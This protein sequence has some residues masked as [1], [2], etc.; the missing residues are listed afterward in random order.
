M[1]IVERNPFGTRSRIAIARSARLCLALLGM[2]A[3]LGQGACQTPGPGGR[4]ASRLPYVIASGQLRVGITGTQPPLSM[5]TKQGEVIGFEVDLINSLANSMGLEAKLV[6][7]PFSELLPALGSGAVD[8]VI[9]GVTITPERNTRVAFVGPYFITGKSILTKSETL[10]RISE[11]TELDD[12]ARS[13]AAVAGSTS[14]DF[15]RH[16]VPKATL[17]TAAG[18][19]EA[20]QLVIDDKV[21]ALIADSH[22]CTFSARR[23]RDMGLETISTPF[24]IEPL[25]IALPPDDPLLVNLVENFLDTLEYTGLLMQLKAKWLSNDSWLAEL[26]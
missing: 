14:E 16:V 10:A 18:H 4:P 5:T 17:V 21:D 1:A 7:L 19:D 23:Y 26:P 8:L 11:T 25:G 15:V 6:V 24:T 13:Y 3:L 9:S 20:V 2:A 12:P 22:I